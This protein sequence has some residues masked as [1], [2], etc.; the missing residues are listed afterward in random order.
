VLTRRNHGRGHSYYADGVKV[1]GVT[2]ILEMMPKPALIGHAG[3]TTAAYAIDHWDELGELPPAER[4]EELKGVRQGELSAAAAR[5]TRVHLIAEH[6]AAGR[7]IEYPAELHG[8]VESYA[9]FLRRFEVEPVAIELIVVNREVGYC[10]TADLIAHL[11][12]EVWLL[13]LKTARSGIFKESA[14]QACAYQHGETYAIAGEDGTEYPMADLGIDR[15]GSVWIRGDGADLRPLDTGPETWEWFQHLA[16]MHHHKDASDEW[17]GAMIDSLMLPG[18]VPPREV[19]SP[20]LSLPEG[21]R[22]R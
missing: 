16:W 2:R 14:L 18:R 13:E 22:N 21:K 9:D 20:A 17:I 10:G 12:G 11:L 7:E 8:F 19:R 6:Q 4:Y 5:G 15:C 3:K 1:P